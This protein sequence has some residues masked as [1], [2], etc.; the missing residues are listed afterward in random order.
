[1]SATNLRVDGA[2]LWESIME[3]AQIGGTAKGGVKRLTLT[4]LDAQ[5]RDW[6]DRRMRGGRVHVHDRRYGQYLRPPP[7]Q[8]ITAWPPSPSAAIWTRSPRGGKFDGIIGVLAGLEVLRT[9]N[10]SGDRDQRARSR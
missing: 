4:D 9:L 5:V 1:M 8:A 3:T 7:G 10:D 2:R 6:F